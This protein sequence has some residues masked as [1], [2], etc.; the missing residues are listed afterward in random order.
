MW[1]LL[2]IRTLCLFC[3]LSFASFLHAE[4]PKSASTKSV[5]F[6]IQL[7][8]ISS[9]F[10][11]KSCWVHPRAGAIPGDVPVVVMTMQK[12][13]IVGSDIFGPLNEMRTDDLGKTWSRPIEHTTSLGLREEPNKISIAASDFWPKWHAKS[14]KLLGIGHNVRYQNNKVMSMRQRETVYSVYDPVNRTWTDW[15]SLI[16]PDSD[17]FYGIEHRCSSDKSTLK[18][19][20]FSEPPS[21][22]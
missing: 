22:N 6:D 1:C 4:S 17:R 8:T 3:I 15:E 11:K 13:A 21:E 12:A 5:A 20:V 16:M 9:G 19:S 18:S 2:V 14:K 7:D 10:D